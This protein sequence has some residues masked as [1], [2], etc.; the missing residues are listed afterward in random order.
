MLNDLVGGMFWM[1][2]SPHTFIDPMRQPILSVLGYYQNYP[3][4]TFFSYLKK[5]SNQEGRDDEE[6]EEQNGSVKVALSL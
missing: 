5:E 1:G 2:V 3:K 6:Q 4:P